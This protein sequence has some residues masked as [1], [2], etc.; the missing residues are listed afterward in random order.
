[1]KQ[2]ETVQKAG[3]GAKT[4]FNKVSTGIKKGAT[5]IWGK[6]GKKKT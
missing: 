6:I 4:G 5:S 3:A 2:N 1:M